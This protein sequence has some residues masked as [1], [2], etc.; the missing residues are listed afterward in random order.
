[1]RTPFKQ[2]VHLK[3]EQAGISEDLAGLWVNEQIAVIRSFPAPNRCMDYTDGEICAIISHGI[4]Q[5]G[6][7]WDGSIVLNLKLEPQ[8]I[9]FNGTL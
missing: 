5:L 3:M 7:A 6:C 2:L 4:I 1:M 9:A 8:G